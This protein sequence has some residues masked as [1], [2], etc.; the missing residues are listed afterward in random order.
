MSVL[1]LL[2]LNGTSEEF[3]LG[4]GEQGRKGDQMKRDKQ[5]KVWKRDFAA[6]GF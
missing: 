5:T 1:P 6:R 3:R 2:V 4:L